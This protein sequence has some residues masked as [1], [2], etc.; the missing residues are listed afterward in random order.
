M[1][2][3]Q[4]LEELI[5]SR[6]EMHDTDELIVL[7]GYVGPRPVERLGELPINSK[8]IYGMY[9]AEGIQARLHGSLTRIQN[10]FEGLDIFYSNLPIHSKCYV[11]RNRGNVIHA[12][13]GSANFSINGLTTPLREVLAE[14]TRD[15]FAPLNEYINH[16]LNN[17]ISCLEIGIV[18]EPL[19]ILGATCAM[20]LVMENGEVHNA[21]GLNWGFMANG[22]PSPKR[23]RNDACIPIKIENINDFP[24]LFPPKLI[25][26]DLIDLRGR[27]QRD[28]EAIEIIWDDEITMEG[29]LEGT[30]KIND[31]VYPKQISSFP[32]KS[33]FGEYLRRR[34][35]VPLGQ[36]VRRH[37]LERY[38]RT[39]IDVSLI[40]E[41]VYSFD[42]SI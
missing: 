40:N 13:V 19:P 12:L 32:S 29:L 17:S 11:W 24:H 7:S 23:G 37:H 26:R 14:T 2:Y 9:G 18:N 31:I 8:V 3:T 39:T 33:Q 36:P 20:S 5:F 1:L 34:I 27:R 30:Q 28:N 15:T 6:H 38:G 41:G 21:S 22:L 10:E 42:F 4:N 25:D 35:G 16:I